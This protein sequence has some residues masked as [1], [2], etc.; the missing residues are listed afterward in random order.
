[1]SLVSR[2]GGASSASAPAIVAGNATPADDYANPTTAIIS[3]SL[4]GLFDGTTWDRWRS[5]LITTISATDLAKGVPSMLPVARYASGA[6]TLVDGEARPLQCDAG[7]FLRTAEQY[8]AVAEDNTNGV[9]AGYQKALATNTYAPS[10]FTNFATDPDVSVKASAGNVYAASCHNLNGAT[11]YFQLHN[12]ATA[13]VGADVPLLVFPVPAGALIL[14]DH[15]NFTQ[16]GTHFTTG[17]ASGFST[18]A[19]TYTAGAA[20]DQYTQIWYK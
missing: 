8:A 14:L 1:M 4:L 5:N 2:S 9:I 6:I 20:G 16:M 11:R 18:T 3:W 13:P 15:M 17:I 7:A 12:K 19:A 10:L